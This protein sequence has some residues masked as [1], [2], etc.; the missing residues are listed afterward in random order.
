M[1][2]GSSVENKITSELHNLQSVISN[3]ISQNS[4][5]VNNTQAV[6]QMIN[7]TFGPGSKTTGCGLSIKQQAN[8]SIASAVSGSLKASTTV[9]NQLDQAIESAVDQLAKASSELLGG[10]ASAVDIMNLKI[11]AKNIISNNV[12]VNNIAQTMNNQI[13]NQGQNVYF[14]GEMDCTGGQTISL[15]QEGIS[16]IVAKQVLDTVSTQLINNKEVQRVAQRVS[17]KGTAESKG[18][19]TLVIMIAVILGLVVVMKL[20]KVN[21]Y[22]ILGLMVLL[23]ILVIVM[24]VKYIWPFKKPS[25]WG[26]AISKDGLMNGK[27]QEY[28]N[29]T[30][31]PYASQEQCEQKMS[32]GTSLNCPSYFGCDLQSDAG[33]KQYKDLGGADGNGAGI[34]SNPF[35]SLDDC[36]TKGSGTCWLEVMKTPSSSLYSSQQE[37]EAQGKCGG[38]L[39]YCVTGE[40]SKTKNKTAVCNLTQV[41]P[42]P[43]SST[44]D[45]KPACT[46]PAG[47][48]DF[49]SKQEDCQKVCK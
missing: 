16:N 2:N 25:H 32:D 23:I 47:C 12:N 7:V 19:W 44:V 28:D 42:P 49:Y 1:G 36:K 43:G 45:G 38:G 48:V 30:D 15:D 11:V 33:C 41:T 35:Y 37:C 14:Y 13:I 31:G 22:I 4:N 26:C 3:I 18:I 34:A 46:N 8:A 20:M 27:C 17:Q 9:D 5:F 24:R 29:D 10:D 40:D 21:P 39:Y 6:D